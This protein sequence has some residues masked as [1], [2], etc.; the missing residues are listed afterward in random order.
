MTTGFMDRFKGKVL[1][2]Y[3][4]LSQ[5]GKGGALTTM[6]G[7]VQG[8]QFAGTVGTGTDTTEDVLYTYTLPANSLVNVGANI[9]VYAFGAFAGNSHTKTAKLYFGQQS[10]TITGTASGTGWALEA[11]IIKQGAN[12]Q[13]ISFQNITGTV[14]G[15]VQNLSDTD[16]DTGSIVIKV[17]GTNGSA[18]QNDIT[19]NGVTVQVAN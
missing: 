8:Q 3:A 16:T 13:Q 6:G 1:A 11:T 10:V 14:H 5:F 19:L 2:S 17:T 4:S 12:L 7:A 15:G 9:W 18:A